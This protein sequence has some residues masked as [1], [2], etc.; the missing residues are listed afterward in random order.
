MSEFNVEAFID[1]QR[2]RGP[3]LLL[4]LVC[5]LVCFIDGFDIFMIGKIAPAIAAG[6][7]EPAE[8]MTLLFLCQQI[9]LAV[10]AFLVAPLADRFGR[11][12]MLV[13]AM[14]IFGVLT[15][16]S[17]LAQTLVQLS[18]MRGIAGIFMSAGLPMALALLSEMTP[19][20]RRSTFLS[21][22]LA[23]YASGSAASGAVAAWLIDIY[24][25]QSGFWIG[26]IVPLACIPLLL[27]FVPE[28]L[29][30][31]AERNPADPR[32]ARIVRRIDPSVALSGDEIFVLA[33]SGAKAQKARLLDVFLDGRAWMTTILWACCLLSMANIAMLGA[34][35]PTFFQTMAGIPI[36]RFAIVAM[37][38]Y[39][40]GLVGTL[41]IGYLMDRVRATTLIP[42]YYI[43]LA[44]ALLAMGA[45]PFDAPFFLAILIF[46]SFVQTGGQAGL[47]TFITQVYPPRMRSTALGWAGGA[48]RIGGV[49]SPV[50]GGL[51]IAQHLSLQ[52]T[53]AFAAA[54]PLIVAIL[55]F[56]LGRVDMAR[57]SLVPATAA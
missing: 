26:G 32:I 18:V 15:L 46:W 41:S 27:L 20:A 17:V 35:L 8:A 14:A 53:L 51:A 44:G 25:W 21:I 10:G 12:T 19:R 29:K 13:V 23:G 9:G 38:A 11:R 57:K 28:S 47:N 1:R 4:L 54:P 31:R 6:F 7:H 37:I 39:G 40:G 42:L 48:G 56:L 22:A 3:Q 52:A 55:V 16:A 33:D 24:G 36:Q 43:G 34:W 2:I 45:V 50:F 49:I 30:Y 5:I